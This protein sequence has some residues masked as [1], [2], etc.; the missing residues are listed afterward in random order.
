MDDALGW[1]V[2]VL[3][4]MGREVVAEPMTLKDRAWSRV[5][6]LTTEDGTVW[7]KVNRGG[8]TYEPALVEALGRL[9]PGSVDEPLAVAGAWMLTSDGGPTL[10]DVRGDSPPDLGAMSEVMREYAA[11]QRATAPHTDGCSPSAS[12]TSAR[13]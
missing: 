5:V 6:R 10:R 4:G 13:R 12:R 1:A 7:L 2:D 11:L 9:T 3:Q 8:T